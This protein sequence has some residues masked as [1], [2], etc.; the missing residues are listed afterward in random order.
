MLSYNLALN[1]LLKCIFFVFTIKCIFFTEL[2]DL[3][4]KIFVAKLL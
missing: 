4:I 1:L 3:I 2:Y